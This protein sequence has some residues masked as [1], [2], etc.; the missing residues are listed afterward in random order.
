MQPVHCLEEYLLNLYPE[1]KRK[2]VAL[3]SKPLRY[4]TSTSD[5]ADIINDY[6]CHAI[7]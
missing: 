2:G 1:N 3:L 6:W 5:T 4:E 7:H